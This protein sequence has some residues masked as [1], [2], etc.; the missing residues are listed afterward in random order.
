MSASGI[1]GD[2][3]SLENSAGSEEDMLGANDFHRVE[4]VSGDDGGRDWREGGDASE[5]STFSSHSPTL[6]REPVGLLTLASGI[7]C[8]GAEFRRARWVVRLGRCA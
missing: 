7:Q 8:L 4:T 5:E 6:V 1:R 2:S 3:E